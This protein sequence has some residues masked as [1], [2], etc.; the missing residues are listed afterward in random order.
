M[1]NK[2]RCSLQA[3]LSQVLNTLQRYQP[4]T[5]QEAWEYD[6]EML[7]GDWAAVGYDIR[8]SINQEEKGE[9]YEIN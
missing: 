2:H 3:K 8:W 9:Q 6:G 1:S 4:M 7:R 5:D